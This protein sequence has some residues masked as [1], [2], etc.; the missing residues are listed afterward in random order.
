MATERLAEVRTS[1]LGRKQQTRNRDWKP[2]YICLISQH[3]IEKTEL[4]SLYTTAPRMWEAKMHKTVALRDS[5]SGENPFFGSLLALAHME[6]GSCVG[7]L[8]RAQIP[9]MGGEG[10]TLPL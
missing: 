10:G 5:I 1:I 8:I 9:F 4:D 7:P 6:Q 3:A 2:Q